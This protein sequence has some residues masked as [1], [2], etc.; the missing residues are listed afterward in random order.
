MTV[1]VPSVLAGQELDCS[2]NLVGSRQTSRST[3]LRKLR[4]D[5]ATYKTRH[6]RLNN[7]WGNRIHGD[8]LSTNLNRHCAHEALDKPLTAGINARAVTRLLR[9]HGRQ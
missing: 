7:P 3:A 6:V 9:G 8:S 2:S 4:A 5:E 1:D